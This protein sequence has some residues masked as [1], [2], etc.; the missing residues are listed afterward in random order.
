MDAKELLAR[1]EGSKGVCQSAINPRGSFVQ[2]E[3][4]IRE[5]QPAEER[6][7]A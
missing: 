6:R 3:G 2:E 1:D 4:R 7:V 5:K